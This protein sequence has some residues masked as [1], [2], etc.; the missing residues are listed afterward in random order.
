MFAI[1]YLVEKEPPENPKILSRFVNPASPFPPRLF[2][3]VV[4]FTFLS[5][6]RLGLWVFDLTTQEITQTG[7]QNQKRSSFAGTEMAFVSFFELSQWVLAAI[8]SRPEH[9][10]LLALGSLGAVLCSACMYSLWVRA[11]R[12]HL[13]HWER[14]GKGCYRAKP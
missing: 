14:L 13:M 9:F 3:A 1:W 6:S 11:Q 8:F 4:M 5:L 2:A 10:H 12:G 7:V